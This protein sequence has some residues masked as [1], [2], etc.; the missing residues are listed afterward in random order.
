MN[1]YKENLF[2]LLLLRNLFL[3]FIFSLILFIFQSGCGDAS[4]FN[5]NMTYIVNRD[6]FTV[7]VE[8]NGI[9]EAKKNITITVPPSL[10]LNEITYLIP[11]GSRVKIG[12]VV[13]IFQDVQLEIEY[14]KSK[15]DLEI[16]KAEKSQKETQHKT[17]K[18]VL[19][20]QLKTYEVSESAAKLRLANLQFISPIRQEIE[21]LEVEKSEME[22][23]KFRQKLKDLEKIQT[24]ER[25][26]AEMKIKQAEIKFKNYAALREQSV[27]K[28]P[29]DG[30][31]AYQTYWDG[32]KV[33]VGD[34]LYRGS[35]ILKIPDLSI[36]QVNMQINENN[37]FKIKQGQRAVITVSSAGNYCFNGKV[38]KVDKVAR[39]I[40]SSSKIKK[41]SVIVEI[42]STNIG[43][44]SGLT[45]ECKIIVEE[46][47]N[48]LMIPKE[49]V[50][51]QDSLK[52]V[53][54]YDNG[55]FEPRAIELSQQGDNFVAVKDGLKEGDR[56]ALYEPSGSYVK[57]LRNLNKKAQ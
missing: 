13:A 32:R 55:R 39:P 18:A 15:N 16:T 50:F 43:L 3:T 25:K 36:M 56:L 51:E 37:A 47:K 8:E 57:T 38:F 5:P 11:E 14:E 30:I 6:D 31:V 21:K 19:E 28:S 1:L 7:T 22:A 17:E 29:I 46:F 27:Q 40:T 20:S 9:L 10:F 26:Y 54:I 48:A 53:Y 35:P 33:Q 42:D 34:I 52:I 41:V 45:A 44:M 24:E 49:C 2:F 12:D 4:R 23:G